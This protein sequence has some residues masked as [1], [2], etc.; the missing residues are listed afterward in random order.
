M[1]PYKKRKKRLWKKAVVSLVILT[2]IVI[3]AWRYFARSG[4]ITEI[5][6]T[7]VNIPSCYLPIGIRDSYLFLASGSSS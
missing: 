4:K 7:K 2:V 1:T 6:T 3:L 5:K